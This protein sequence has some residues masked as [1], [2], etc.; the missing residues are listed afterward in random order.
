MKDVAPAG[1]GFSEEDVIEG[2][3]ELRAYIDL[4]PNDF[5]QLY[6]HVHKIARRRI[7]QQISAAD[8][9]TSP[10]TVVGESLTLEEAVGVLAGRRISGAPVVDGENR[11]TGVI[12]EK[13]I[14]RVLGENPT[15][16][17]MNV[18]DS[19]LRRTFEF[20]ETP[21]LKRVG[22]IMSRPAVS[23]GPE[24]RLGDIVRLFEEKSINRLPVADSSGA[25]LGIITRS[26]VITAVSRL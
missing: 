4:T 11:L 6:E 24:S 22:E 2:M 23:V 16:G 12:S 1:T 14:L 7:F 20:G 18:V 5:K 15:A 9:M 3:K 10:A 8:I 26:N 19:C 13:D 21:G 25:V 17:L